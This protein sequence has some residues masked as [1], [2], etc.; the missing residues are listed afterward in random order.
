MGECCSGVSILSLGFVGTCLHAAYGSSRKERFGEHNRSGDIINGD[1][2][3]QVASCVQVASKHCVRTRTTK[4]RI[5]VFAAQ[6]CGCFA[7]MTTSSHAAKYGQPM[8]SR[9]LLII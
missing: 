7:I 5:R 8:R 9:P 6:I 3:R 2:G 4:P 1:S